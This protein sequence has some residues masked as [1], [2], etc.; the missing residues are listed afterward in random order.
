[1]GPLTLLSV[2]VGANLVSRGFKQDVV[3]ASDPSF[4]IGKGSAI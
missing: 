2:I 3:E 4:R 1:M